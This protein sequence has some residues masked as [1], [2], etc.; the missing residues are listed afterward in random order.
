MG[1]RGGGGKFKTRMYDC[2]P[3]GWL[4]TFLNKRSRELEKKI[5]G[6]FFALEFFFGKNKGEDVSVGLP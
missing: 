2:A 1:E 5:F 6:D 3:I 4:S